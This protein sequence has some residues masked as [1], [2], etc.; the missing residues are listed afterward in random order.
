MEFAIALTASNIIILLRFLVL[1]IAPLS[2]ILFKL[3]K[4]T[5]IS[6]K[7]EIIGGPATLPLLGNA[8][9]LIGIDAAGKHLQHL[10]FL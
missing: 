9:S 4:N 8:H 1:F 5:K 7:L 10:I 2:Y 6:Q 3:R